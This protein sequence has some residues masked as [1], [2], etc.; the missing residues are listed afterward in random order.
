MTDAGLTHVAIEVSDLQRSIDFYAAYGG[1]EVVHRREGIAWISDRTRSAVL[2]MPPWV[3]VIMLS[4]PRA[5]SF[6]IVSPLHNH[7]VPHPAAH[8]FQ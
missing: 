2:D 3:L 8:G 1:F 5:K 7:G 6:H 4:E